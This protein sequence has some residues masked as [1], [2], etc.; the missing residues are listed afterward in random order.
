MY[1]FQQHIDSLI[2]TYS[3][4]YTHLC[5]ITSKKKENLLCRIIFSLMQKYI[6]TYIYIQ[7]YILIYIYTDL[8][9]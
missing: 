2:Y 6:L 5:R 7:P 4:I 8:Y 3:F 1:C 9:I